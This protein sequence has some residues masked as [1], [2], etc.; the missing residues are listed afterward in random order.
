MNSGHTSYQDILK[1]L[2]ITQDSSNEFLT[3]DQLLK[4]LCFSKTRP[5]DPGVLKE[6][7]QE[8]GFNPNIGINIEDFIEAFVKT[9]KKLRGKVESAKQQVKEMSGSLIRVKKEL[10]EAK[11][12]KAPED[13]NLLTVTVVQAEFSCKE[14]L[15]ARVICD[16]WE[17]TSNS[18]SSGEPWNETFTFNPQ[19]PNDIQIE[20]WVELNNTLDTL[21][22]SVQVN[23]SQLQN[24]EPLEKWFKI[25]PKNPKITQV[26]IKL[27]WV[28]SKI[29]Y[30]SRV[31]S[32]NEA[33]IEEN[34]KVLDLAEEKHGKILN[35]LIEG[36]KSEGI[37]EEISKGLDQ[38]LADI[39]KKK[40]W[41]IG[42]YVCLYLCIILSVLS[43]ILGASGVNVFGN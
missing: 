30:L 25:L 16:E 11:A 4:V 38:F 33:K 31:V 35:P 43:M 41:V 40:D 29:E 12:N 37:D 20:F 34:R 2:L 7:F 21:L 3:Y 36:K 42:Y 13:F 19:N 9:E 23:F 1:S 28:R 15:V 6:V 26:L 10:I 5:L 32:E 22:A 24:E 27:H 8:S 18:V 39:G 17:V 14:K